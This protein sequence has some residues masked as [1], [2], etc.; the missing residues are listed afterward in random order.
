MHLSASRSIDY[1]NY[2]TILLLVFGSTISCSNSELNN[3]MGELSQTADDIQI[4][5]YYTTLTRIYGDTQSFY[6]RMI[7]PT[8]DDLFTIF[9]IKDYILLICCHYHCTPNYHSL[10]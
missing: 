5:W 10:T 4:V 9:K 7:S 3:K 6:P 1:L 8:G 2:I